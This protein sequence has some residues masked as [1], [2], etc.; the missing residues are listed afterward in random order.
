MADAHYSE[1]RTMTR[2]TLGLGLVFVLAQCTTA[3][4]GGV[5]G[6]ALFAL[7][8]ELTR[9]INKTTARSPTAAVAA[10]VVTAQGMLAQGAAG[11]VKAD[12]RDATHV[13]RASKWHVGS[14]TK[15]MTAAL[16]SVL[17]SDGQTGAL[18][19]GG[20]RLDVQRRHA[21]GP[22]Q[23]RRGIPSASPAKRMVASA[24]RLLRRTSANV[25]TAVSQRVR[26]LR[27]PGARAASARDV[28]R[29]R[30]GKFAQGDAKRHDAV[31]V[32]EGWLRRARARCKRG[33]SGARAA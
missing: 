20:C 18:R 14:I 21:Q 31:Q 22:R 27:A 9:I 13:T 3:C 11:R 25:E 6:E 26:A 5:E 7:D 24:R 8:D 23:P 33:G 1:G 12:D 17:E 19:A 30:H 29:T 32:L 28:Q 4:A 2:L 15:A 16:V 10:T